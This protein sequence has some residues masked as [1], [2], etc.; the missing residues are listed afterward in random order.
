MNYIYMLPAAFLVPVIHEWVKAMVSTAQ[1]DPTPRQHGFVTL[2]PFRYFEPVG[3]LFVLLFGFGWGN[4]TPTAALHYKNRQQGVVI[5]YVTPVLINLLLG[6][7][8]V[9]GVNILLNIHYGQVNYNMFFLSI[10]MAMWTS[11]PYYIAILVLSHFAMVNINIA[12]FNLLPVYPLAAN[13]LLLL[14][15]RPDTIAR[16]NHYEKPMQ[17]AMIV[18]LA[19]NIIA[20]ILS[21]ILHII[22]RIVWGFTI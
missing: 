15:S 18:M 21:P 14:F 4:P 6:I 10:R 1:G 16:V 9:I 12:L 17:I 11:D 13:R 7:G 19:F 20:M 8:A 5:T 2:N 3:F 22:V